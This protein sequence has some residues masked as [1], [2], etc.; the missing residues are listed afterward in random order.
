M[1]TQASEVLPCPICG[2]DTIDVCRAI[3]LLDADYLG[4]QEE[5]FRHK[6][7]VICSFSREGCGTSSGIK[8]TPDLAK[9]AWNRRVP[10]GE[11]MVLGNE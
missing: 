2:K 7:V 1:G 3:E 11:R 8:D 5:E 9:E 6:Y 4:E 10:T